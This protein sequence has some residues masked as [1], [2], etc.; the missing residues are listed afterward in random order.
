VVRFKSVAIPAVVLELFMG[1]LIGP[2]LLGLELSPFIAFF[3]DLG[4]GMLF[5]F[6]GYE[7]DLHRILGLP[8]RLGVAGWALS[9]VLA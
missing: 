9:L 1:I 5:F 6:A 7:L 2:H 8:L 4:L 3:S